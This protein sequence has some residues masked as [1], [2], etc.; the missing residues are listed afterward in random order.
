MEVKVTGTLALS[1]RGSPSLLKGPAVLA[2]VISEGFMVR[3][4]GLLRQ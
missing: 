4:E 1:W 2:T 3:A